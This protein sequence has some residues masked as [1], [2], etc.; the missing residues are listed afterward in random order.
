MTLFLALTALQFV[1]SSNLPNSRCGTHLGLSVTR[2]VLGFRHALCRLSSRCRVTRGWWRRQGG[3]LIRMLFAMFVSCAAT[4][5]ED[6]P[7]P[8]RMCPP[9]QLRAQ[10]AGACADGLR[11]A[12]PKTLTSSE[13]PVISFC[14]RAASPSTRKARQEFL[15]VPNMFSD[16]HTRG[17]TI[18][19]RSPVFTVS[20]C[21]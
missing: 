10:D 15:L 5:H 19:A 9:V 6:T 11:C 7:H 21:A 8:T 1:I 16:V 13:T 14:H 20:C 12:T 2:L 3:P 18:P 17:C 4:P